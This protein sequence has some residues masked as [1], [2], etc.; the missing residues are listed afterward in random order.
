MGSKI[1]AAGLGCFA[2]GRKSAGHASGR[3]ARE[4]PSPHPPAL[5]ACDQRSTAMTVFASMVTVPVL[6]SASTAS[7]TNT[8]C[9]IS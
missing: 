1:V 3:V 7:G 2:S 6:V 4:T 9:T 8:T 5:D